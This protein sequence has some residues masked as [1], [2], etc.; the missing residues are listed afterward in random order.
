MNSV[1]SSGYATAQSLGQQEPEPTELESLLA[2]L[3]NATR[4]IR[5]DLNSTEASLRMYLRPAYDPADKNVGNVSAPVP[6]RSPL[7]TRIADIVEQLLSID[8]YVVSIR[9]RL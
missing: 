6:I 4:W 7:E 2:A 8:A 5:E 1:K 9:S 3:E